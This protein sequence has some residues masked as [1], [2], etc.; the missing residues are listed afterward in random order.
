M[1]EGGVG[2]CLGRVGFSTNWVPLSKGL[3][4]FTFTGPLESRA[5]TDKQRVW[6][7]LPFSCPENQR[8]K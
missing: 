6:I 5:K 8:R 2:Q 1:C 7:L 4:F 3:S